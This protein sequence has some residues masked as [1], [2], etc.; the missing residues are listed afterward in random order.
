MRLDGVYRHDEVSLEEGHGEDDMPDWSAL[1]HEYDRHE[2][3]IF[4]NDEPCNTVPDVSDP[5]V[6]WWLLPPLAG[7]KM[8]IGSRAP[9]FEPRHS[10]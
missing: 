2:L 10:G 9:G 8:L 7:A 1:G 5:K 6:S 3:F 4:G